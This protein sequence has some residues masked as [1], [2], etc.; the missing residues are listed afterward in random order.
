MLTFY[1]SD[2]GTHRGFCKICG[3]ALFSKF[4]NKDEFGFSLGTLDTDPAVKA[5]YHIFVSEKAAW[6]EITDELPQYEKFPAN[7][8]V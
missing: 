4:D 2:P 1:E 7:I 3:S 6:F 8:K 5:Q